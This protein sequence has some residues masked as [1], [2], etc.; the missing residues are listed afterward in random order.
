MKRIL[1]GGIGNVLLGDDGVGPLIARTIG[2]RCER[3]SGVEVEDLG[4]PGLE[5]ADYLAGM[6]AV[7]L[8]DSIVSEE[9]PG[10]IKLFRKP[11]IFA[12]QVPIRTGPHAPSLI[13]TLVNL[14]LIG[15]APEELLLVGVV[16]KSFKFGM[17]LS[18][19]VRRSVEPA[20]A[21]IFDEIARLQVNLKLKE[22][23]C[24]PEIW[25]EKQVL[26]ETA[27][28]KPL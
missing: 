24:A 25:W 21:A 14:D 27:Q 15:A 18:D 16:G 23:S 4:T 9:Q 8:V 2:A 6:N 1:I 17:P 10:S 20:I 19:C 7:I 3:C 13:E 22:L 12:C 26:P 5:L 28:S 11:D